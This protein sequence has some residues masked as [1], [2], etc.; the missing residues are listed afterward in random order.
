[1]KTWQ[2]IGAI[3]LVGIGVPIGCSVMN[4]AT[5]VAT[6]PGKVVQ[7]TFQADNIITNYEWYYDTYAAYEARLGQITDHS[8]YLEAEEDRIEIQRLRIELTAMR[9]SCRDLATKYNANSQKVNKSIF[10]GGAVPETIEKE[11]CNA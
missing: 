6:A 5:T 10:K 1:M 3:A 2:V 8:S 11:K 9:Q 7:K 4:T